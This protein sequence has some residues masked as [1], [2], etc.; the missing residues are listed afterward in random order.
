VFR[1][2]E[3][4]DA[5]RDRADERRRTE[6]DAGPPATRMATRMASVGADAGNGRATSASGATTS[7]GY[8]S[9]SDRRRSVDDPVRASDVHVLVVDDE[10]ICRTVTSRLLR[11]CGYRVTT[12]QSGAEAL[13][14]LRRGTEFHLLLTDVMMPGIDGPA[15]LQL[16]RNDERLRDMPVIMMSANEHSE[17]VFRC[18]QYGAE[19]YL[20]KPVSRK[21]V[22]HMWQHVWRRNQLSLARAV[23]RYENGEEIHEEEDR[24]EMVHGVPAVPQHDAE[25]D[26]VIVDEDDDSHENHG[27]IVHH[28]LHGDDMGDSPEAKAKTRMVDAESAQ[29]VG[30][31]L[32]S[33]GAVNALAGA[34][35]LRLKNSS[36]SMTD[37]D[38]TGMP[39]SE[40]EMHQQRVPEQTR[41]ALPPP[42]CGFHSS[43][44]TRVLREWLDDE[45]SGAQ[46]TSLEDRLHV[47]A[48]LAAFVELNQSRCVSSVDMFDAGRLEISPQGAI[49]FASPVAD[50]NAS[51]SAADD[52]ADDNVAPFSELARELGRK[53]LEF[54]LGLICL[55]MFFPRVFV[56][57]YE[58][59][60]G[61][62]ALDKV[63]SMTGF[64]QSMKA[65]I[66]VATIVVSMLKEDSNRLSAK[67]A[68]VQFQRL[69]GEARSSG[70][71]SEARVESLK[72]LEIILETL[73]TARESQSNELSSSLKVLGVL[74]CE[75]GVK[76][77]GDASQKRDRSSSPSLGDS[78][79]LKRARTELAESATNVAN[80]CVDDKE[81]SVLCYDEENIALNDLKAT[82]KSAFRSAKTLEK[83]VFADL[84]RSLFA[85][86]ARAAAAKISGESAPESDS[87]W[88]KQMVETTGGGSLVSDAL[89]SFEL[90]LCSVTREVSIRRCASIGGDF[91]DFA[92]NNSMVCCASWDRDGELFATAGTSK[93]ICVYDSSAVMQMGARVH[94]PAVEFEAQ[95][96]VSALSCNPYVKQSLASGDYQGVVQLWDVNREK[97][98]WENPTHR[99]R[100]WSIDFSGVD[101]TRLASA[102]DD[103][104]VRVYSTT[105]KESIC[106]LQN[107]ANVCSVKFHP[108]NA[109]ILAIGSADHRLMCYDLRQPNTPMLSLQGHRKAVSYVRWIGDE[110][111]SASTDNTLKLWDIKCGDPR[112]M[113]VRT[114]TGHTNEKNFV[115][116]SVSQDGYIACGSE[117]N[118]VHVYSKH[119]S[120]PVAQYAFND[121]VNG[122]TSNRRDKGGF[123]SSVAWSPDSKHL[124]A[125]NSRGHLKILQ[126]SKA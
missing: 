28:G 62:S 117:D 119:S 11:N 126:L 35:A 16:V 66:D 102:S 60:D 64:A 44:S 89:E 34:G 123:I 55:N 6:E 86:S 67:H 116:L 85:K 88:L 111:I 54:V 118:V 106:T 13:E 83:N 72:R 52:D 124:L 46:N 100:V 61:D 38:S 22:K 56:D 39:S 23:P 94:C 70:V 53:E 73:R 10:R 103:G 107:R 2:R 79:T 104:S 58:S 114:Y 77:V 8:G 42:L 74:L 75:I 93:S 110:I 125:A 47:A 63:V 19:D 120:V 30:E 51:A 33:N 24:G 122:F 65:H 90:D 40:V 108:S 3:E 105:T 26:G 49:S 31:R 69:A 59:K 17:T 36:V 50:R 78:P 98:V 5:A 7:G 21:A 97:S 1:R 37:V 113:C 4:A 109:H 18:I 25:H 15:L 71:E 121:K 95:A 101:P 81:A 12:A 76:D 115:G 82:V 91:A 43:S 32:G 80:L 112:R 99:R 29:R 14:L 27:V 9:I 20:L 87:K 92:A 48:Q 41:R 57:M 68:S 96:K 84:E 45:T